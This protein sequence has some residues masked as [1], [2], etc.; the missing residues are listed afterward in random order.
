MKGMRGMT[1]SDLQRV[2]PVYDEIRVMH[3]KVVIENVIV[4]T[5]GWMLYEKKLTLYAIE[6]DAEAWEKEREGKTF[7]KQRKRAWT[8]REEVLRKYQCIDYEMPFMRLKSIIIDDIQ[9]NVNGATSTRIDKE[10]L[11]EALLILNEFVREGIKVSEEMVD[12]NLE[13]ISLTSIE[14]E[15]EYDTIPVETSVGKILLNQD[16]KYLHYL[17]QKT[18]KLEVGKKYPKSFKC[19]KDE[20]A[21]E[22]YINQVYLMNLQEEIDKIFKHPKVREQLSEDEICKRKEEAKQEIEKI[23][24]KGT[25][26]P[27]IEYEVQTRDLNLEIYTKNYLDKEPTNASSSM[28]ILI[29]SDKQEGEHGLPVKAVALHEGVAED[30]TTLEVEV[31]GYILRVDGEVIEL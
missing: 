17:I 20:Q 23:Y 10:E 27:V 13:G 31:I 1:L 3:R 12:V 8:N 16:N 7:Q 5:L 29:K 6:Y 15:G 24:P 2:Q 11:Q 22:F 30:T 21:F 4:E 14:V 26:L 19:G 9:F 25:L 18:L 28:G